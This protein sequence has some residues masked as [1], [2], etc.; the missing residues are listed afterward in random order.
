M[1]LVCIV[2]HFWN[3]CIIPGRTPPQLCMCPVYIQ[4]YIWTYHHGAIVR[5]FENSNS[6]SI[7]LSNKNYMDSLIQRQRV[8]IRSLGLIS[9]Y[10][11][12]GF[13]NQ[14]F[15]I[16][17]PLDMFPRHGRMMLDYVRRLAIFDNAGWSCLCPAQ[18]P[19]MSSP[20][21]IQ[22]ANFWKVGG[23]KISEIFLRSDLIKYI[24]SNYNTRWDCRS[25]FNVC[26]HKR[27]LIRID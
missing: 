10:T 26:Q 4:L 16:L 19:A 21:L 13:R 22:A 15:W 7:V 25:P 27:A 11:W 18:C 2:F 6:R 23:V 20:C 1:V 17:D 14:M 5:K 12:K 3:V 9:A 8:F 24:H